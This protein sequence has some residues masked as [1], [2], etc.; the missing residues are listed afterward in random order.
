MLKKGLYIILV[1]ITMILLF[2][3]VFQMKLKYVDIEP[4]KGVTHKQKIPAFTFKS[5]LDFKYQPKL[6]KYLVENYGFREYAIRLYNQIHFSLYKK[7][8]SHV[9]VGIDNYLFEPWFIKSHNGEDYIGEEKISDQIHKLQ[10]ISDTLLA[11]NKELVIILAPG[12]VAYWPEF[13]PSHYLK[14]GID[15]TNY[16]VFASELS[17]STIKY[18][19]INHWYMLAK[20]TSIYHLFPKTGT[21]WS[22][23]GAGVAYDSIIHYIKKKTSFNLVD[24]KIVDI[25]VKS[26]FKKA[27]INIDIENV[28]NLMYPLDRLEIAFPRLKLYNKKNADKPNTIFISDSFFWNIFNH[29]PTKGK[30]FGDLQFWYYNKTIYPESYK[31]RIT[32]EQI[33][34]DNVIA[35]TDLIVIMACPVTIKELGWGFIDRAY[36]Y[37]YV[38]E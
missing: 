20:D 1:V 4:L 26:E 7:G 25:K 32:P 29:Y 6:Y 15:N 22:S 33:S 28:L 16:K 34:F 36:N 2:L 5:W 18:I 9:I 8:S 21:H 13:V 17:K 37:F 30:V 10:L 11:L 12:K 24:T 19:D 3:P 23:Y 38:K 27:D 31:K 35:E 14:P